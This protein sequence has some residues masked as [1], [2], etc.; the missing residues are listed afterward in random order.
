MHIAGRFLFYRMK[1]FFFI[2][3][4]FLFQ[5]EPI[6]VQSSIQ[7]FS[8]AVS[9]AVTV[10]N[11]FIVCDQKTN[12]L[13][14]YTKDTKELR[15]FGGQGWG[16]YEFDNPIDVWSSFLLE[17]FVTDRNN[18]RIQ[19]YDKEL[20]YIQT[21][22]ENSL[23]NLQGR[24][25]PLA[26][27]TTTQGNLFVIESDGNRILK[28]NR[29][30]QVEKEFGTFKD[31]EG[32]LHNPEDIAISISNDIFVLD[33]TQIKVFDYF[34]NYLRTIQL[35]QNQLWKTIHQYDNGIIVT[36][37]QNI[38]VYTFDGILQQNILR[39]NTFGVDTKED[40]QDA[41]IT[42]GLLYILSSSSLYRCTL[43]N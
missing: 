14:F 42:N 36:S 33:E 8:H 38:A 27:A 21:Y 2:L 12:K 6:V 4:L 40:F 39:E 43:S 25:Y 19:K 18:R 32:S 15:Q 31:G 9:F 28:I 3:S 26:C 10:N 41:V 7:N 13:F 23:V 34:G 11:S 20:N 30:G 37:S 24:F 22:D 5:G 35:N 16:N 1:T 17:T 29:R